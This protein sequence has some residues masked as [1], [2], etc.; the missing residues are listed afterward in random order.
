ML[1]WFRGS[2]R[3]SLPVGQRVYAIGD[4]HGRIDLLEA[5]L[6]TIRNDNAARADAQ[7]TLIT[8]G[9]LVD[10]GPASREVV[11]RIRGGVEWAR[12]I[13]IMGNHEAIMMQVLDGKK[14]SLQSWLRYGGRETLESWDVPAAILADGTLDQILDAARGAVTAEER[15]WL[16]RLRSYV[17]MGNYYFVHAG[18][19]PG[20]PLEQQD[21]EDRLWIRDEFL[22]SSKK[23]GAMIVH[24]HSIN[25]AVEERP[26]RIGID[27]GAYATGKLTALGIEGRERWLLS[28]PLSNPDAVF[29]RDDPLA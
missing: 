25:P 20:V 7:V 5:L 16:G 27:T 28:T 17:R 22:E 3:P 23:H 12:T 29:E 21:D 8:L 14:D 6:E 2:S 1:N 9:D 18:I 15:G 26:N 11:T 10:R 13:S 19:R 4:V 24:G